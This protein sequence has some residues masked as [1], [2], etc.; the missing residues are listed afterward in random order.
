M[1]RNSVVSGVCLLAFFSFVLS[2]CG[3]PPPSNTDPIAAAMVERAGIRPGDVLFQSLEGELAAMIESATGSPYSHCGIVVRYRGGDLGVLEALGRVKVTP[4]REFIARG[5]QQYLAV[6]RPTE[7]YTARIPAILAA[8]YRYRGRPYDTRYRLDDEFIYC[9]E[10]VYKGF[11][12]ATGEPPG[13]T[14]Y[15]RELHWQPWRALI[16]KLEGGPVPVEREL[17]TPRDLARA[18]QLRQVWSNYPGGW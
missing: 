6:Y 12:D 13:R 16:R 11:R 1:Q 9:S 18:R 2:G 4:I 17:I 3:E 7:R 10:L 15:L 5:R 14:V 8:C